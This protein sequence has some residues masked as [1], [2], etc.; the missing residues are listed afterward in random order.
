M[1][2]REN[3]PE[4]VMFNTSKYE[5][6]VQRRKINKI[7]C[8]LP[9]PLSVFASCG[10][11]SRF[12]R[13]DVT[14]LAW[15]R[16]ITPVSQVRRSVDLE[17]YQICLGDGVALAHGA[18]AEHDEWCTALHHLEKKTKKKGVKVSSSSERGRSSWMREGGAVGFAERT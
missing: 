17:T 13:C 11:W 12:T 5:V 2:T 15:A 16:G 4:N 10:T 6:F 3:N 18:V 7:K 9:G 1:V 8:C 14:A